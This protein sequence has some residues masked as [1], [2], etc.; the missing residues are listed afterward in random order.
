[1]Y[2]T[3]PRKRDIQS[4][5]EK[6]DKV[7]TDVFDDTA[8]QS[9]IILAAGLSGYMTN[10]SQRWFELRPRDFRLLESPG[11]KTFFSETA[12]IIYSVLATTNFYQQVNE[13]Y[14]DLGAIGT[15]AM[16]ISEDEIED[17]KKEIEQEAKDE[18]PEDNQQDEPGAPPQQIDSNPQNEPK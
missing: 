13:L 15:A 9:N 5:I 10:A 1:M 2:Y 11:V 7:P 17:I 18:P 3:M 14:L 8:I 6:G 16:Y 12:E 4:I